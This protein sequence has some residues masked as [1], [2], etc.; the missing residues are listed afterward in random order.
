MDLN[1]IVGPH[2]DRI[3]SLPDADR[4]T[5]RLVGIDAMQAAEARFIE[6]LE[7]EPIDLSEIDALEDGVRDRLKRKLRKTL[8]GCYKL[9][10]RMSDHW[11][12]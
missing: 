1:L 11:W 12:Y 7:N 5:L 3:A 8:I 9:G 10:W 6:G 4:V 2:F